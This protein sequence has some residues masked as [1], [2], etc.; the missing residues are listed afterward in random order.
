MKGGGATRPEDESG[1]PF[2]LQRK[3]PPL[4]YNP[5]LDVMWLLLFGLAAGTRMFNL[6][7]PNS[8]V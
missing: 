7:S 2:N 1:E 8:V 6:M 4:V 3:A 5:Q